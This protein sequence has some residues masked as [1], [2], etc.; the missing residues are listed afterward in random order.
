MEKKKRGRPMSS[1][2][3]KVTPEF[4]DNPD[5]EKLGRALIAVGISLA[6]KKMAEENSGKG[7][8]QGG[9]MTR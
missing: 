8:G 7:G 3:V 2:D 1:A 6:Q 5:L 4:R 9:G